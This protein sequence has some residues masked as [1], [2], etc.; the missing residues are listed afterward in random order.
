MV[1]N[2]KKFRDYLP[3]GQFDTPNHISGGD[4]LPELI[5]LPLPPLRL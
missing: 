5:P 3:I 2:Y 4:A 1:E